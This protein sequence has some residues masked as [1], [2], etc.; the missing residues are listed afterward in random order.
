M[1]RD[2]SRKIIALLL[3]IIGVALIV[4]PYAQEYASANAQKEL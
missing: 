2:K 1:Q 4:K 3:V